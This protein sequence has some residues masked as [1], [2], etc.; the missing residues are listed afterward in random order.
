VRAKGIR[1]RGRAPAP[2]GVDSIATSPSRRELKRQLVY[3]LREAAHQASPEMAALLGRVA[4]RLSTCGSAPIPTTDPEATIGLRM[5][6]DGTGRHYRGVMHCNRILCPCCSAFI[7][8]MRMEQLKPLIE[9][10]RH[11]GRHIFVTLTLRHHLGVLW[12]E[13]AADIKGSWKQVQQTTVFRRTVRGGVRQDETTWGLHGHHFHSHLLLT[14]LED[15]DP[16]QFATW[17][18]ERF[19]SAA[20]KRGRTCDWQEGWWSEVAPGNLSEVL[21]YGSKSGGTLEHLIGAELLASGEKAGSRPW[22]L[23][24]DVY[25]EVW[26]DSKRHRWFS[27]F[28]I[29]RLNREDEAKTEEQLAEEGREATG[30]EVRSVLVADYKRLTPAQN[31]LLE[32]VVFDPR[33]GRDAV[34]RAWD[35]FWTV[36]HEDVPGPSG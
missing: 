1:A 13:L 8:A 4:W 10:N 5:R 19:E 22:D 34:L 17:F 35:T 30:Q 24:E 32:G 9:A 7:R 3:R 21:A 28:G 12:D 11:A 33:R 16:E 14:V 25:A 23:P 31:E 20:T 18:R 26:R 6:E 29:W 36:F 2:G 27:A 15:L